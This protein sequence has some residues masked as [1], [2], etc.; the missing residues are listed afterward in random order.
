MRQVTIATVQMKPQL[1]EMEENLVAMSNWIKQIATEQQVDLIVFPELITTGYEC[2]VGFTD[3]AQR[4]P[5]PGGVEGSGGCVDRQSELPVVDSRCAA[6]VAVVVRDQQGV[7]LGNNAPVG[8][9]PL[10]GLLAA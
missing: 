4:V 1:G 2:G 8:R 7:D 5:I 6:M 3:F 9:Q 10:L